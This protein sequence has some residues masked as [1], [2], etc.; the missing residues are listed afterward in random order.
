M[1]L[2]TKLKLYVT[3]DIVGLIMN[4]LQSIKIEIT[5]WT[6]YICLFIA[7]IS[8]IISYT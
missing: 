2:G 7:D 6:K 3:F 4:S 1:F 8:I 5:F